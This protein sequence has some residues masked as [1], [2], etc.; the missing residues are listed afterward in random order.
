MVIKCDICFYTELKVWPGHGKR[1]VQKG[2][3]NKKNIFN[4]NF[5]LIRKARDFLEPKGL[6]AQRPEDQGPT[7][8]MDS[9]LA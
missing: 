4:F 8:D 3:N 2:L 7:L 1:C 5:L 6:V 9:G